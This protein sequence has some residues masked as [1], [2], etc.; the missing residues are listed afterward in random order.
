MSFI[1]IRDCHRGTSLREDGRRTNSARVDEFGLLRPGG[2]RV[3]FAIV[4]S[5]DALVDLLIGPLV[6]LIVIAHPELGA[7]GGAFPPPRGTA[8]AAATG[9]G[10]RTPSPQPAR[11]P[12]EFSW[13]LSRR[14]PFQALHENPAL[15]H[16]WGSVIIPELHCAAPCWRPTSNGWTPS[17]D[18]EPED[19]KR[20]E[21]L[22]TRAA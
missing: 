19:R 17:E 3:S 9:R 8:S 21:S 7:A 13:T 14:I 20:G 22:E 1:S 15:R 2:S 11:P 5:Q 10:H 16:I 4:R 12:A 6:L 18:A